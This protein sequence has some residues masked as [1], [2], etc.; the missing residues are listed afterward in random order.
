M[1]DD[2]VSSSS[3]LPKVVIITG[4]GRGIG[5]AA[6][7]AAARCGYAV[8]VNYR[9]EHEAARSVVE[10][11]GAELGR[12]IA[13]RGDVAVP[14]DVAGLFDQTEQ[15]FGTVTALVN[16]AGTTGRITRFEELDLPTLRRVIDVNLIGCML[17]SQ[18]AVRRWSPA[19]G[20]KGGSIV[21]LSSVAA[22]L[23]SP[24]EYVHYA[25]TKAAVE[26]FTVGLAREVAKEGIRVNAVSPGTVQTG[27]HAAG[28]DP[29]RPARVAA[30]I[31]MGRVGQPEEI[32]AAILWLL[33]PAASYVT[34]SV[35]T[36][37]GGL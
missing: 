23:G 1:T 22:T 36:V 32:A 29:D 34:G 2:S 28:G 16:N 25:A 33:S 20:G 31:P 3:A 9:R 30:R 37:S 15:A 8:A 11:I 21:N 26:A 13:V 18:E 12:A 19:R 35:L 27:I 4:A 5:A 17:C 7:F 14:A 6:A 24:G 10:R